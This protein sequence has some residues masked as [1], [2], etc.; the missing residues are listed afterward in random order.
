[1]CAVSVHLGQIQG[2]GHVKSTYAVWFGKPD[3]GM[4]IPVEQIKAVRNIIV[5]TGAPGIFSAT[6]FAIGTRS[7]LAIVWLMNVEM[8]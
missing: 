1:M 8:T 4:P 3:T 7:T 5:L 2:G 6:C